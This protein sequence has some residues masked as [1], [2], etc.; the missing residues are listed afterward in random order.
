MLDACKDKELIS[1]AVIILFPFIFNVEI[2]GSYDQSARLDIFS[3]VATGTPFKRSSFPPAVV[4]IAPS[5]IIPRVLI[6][7]MYASSASRYTVDNDP[8]RRSITVAFACTS[9]VDVIVLIEYKVS[10]DDTADP[11]PPSPDKTT[12]YEAYVS[13]DNICG[14]DSI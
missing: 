6:L 10:N 3:V 1:F 5:N 7:L 9:K 11:P 13:C 12:P 8:A 4:S 14:S 2:A